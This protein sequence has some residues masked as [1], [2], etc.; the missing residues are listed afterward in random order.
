MPTISQIFWNALVLRIQPPVSIY[1]REMMPSNKLYV[2][3][4][5]CLLFQLYLESQ[6]GRLRP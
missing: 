1:N 6:A 3:Q 4:L 5:H 2:E